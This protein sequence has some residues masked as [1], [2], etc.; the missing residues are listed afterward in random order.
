MD[1]TNRPR[2]GR[3]R[4]AVGG[5]FRGAHGTG[6]KTRRCRVSGTCTSALAAVN[7]I[8]STSWDESRWVHLPLTRQR[9]LVFRLPWAPRSAPPTAK[10]ICPLRGR[11]VALLVYGGTSKGSTTGGPVVKT[12]ACRVPLLPFAVPDLTYDPPALTVLQ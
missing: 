11:D 8:R 7:T 5:A 6:P 9:S 2:S 3:V 1:T 12:A 10:G 4:L